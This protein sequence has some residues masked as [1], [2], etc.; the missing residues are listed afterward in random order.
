MNGKKNKTEGKR[1]QEKGDNVYFANRAR[2]AFPVTDSYFGANEGIL[3][4]FV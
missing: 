2:R 3:R 1:K 4:R